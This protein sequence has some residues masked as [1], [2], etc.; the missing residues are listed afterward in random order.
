MPGGLCSVP[1]SRLNHSAG[2]PPLRRPCPDVQCTNG[3]TGA[4]GF[5]C[6]CCDLG[7]M[8]CRAFPLCCQC[9]S[10]SVCVPYSFLPDRSAHFAPCGHGLEW[11]PCIQISAVPVLVPVLAVVALAESVAAYIHLLR[12]VEPTAPPSWPLPSHLIATFLSGPILMSRTFQF[13]RSVPSDSRTP[14][15]LAFGLCCSCIPALASR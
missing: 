9:I 3:V 10:I 12:V 15:R 4:C 7:C 13:F 8:S 6:V 5:G 14:L 11:M 2:E 1:T